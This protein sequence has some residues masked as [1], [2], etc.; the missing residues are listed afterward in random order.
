MRQYSIGKRLVEGYLHQ[1][2]TWFLN[3]H[4]SDLGTNILTEVSNVIGGGLSSLL[5]LIAKS[6][7]TSAIIILLIITITVNTQ[8][9]TSSQLLK[10]MAGK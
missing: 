10:A 2:Y 3:H 8:P 9:D 4:S 1:P 6:M 5:E 7:V